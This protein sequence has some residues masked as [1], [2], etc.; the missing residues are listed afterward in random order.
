M[1]P[2]EKLPDLVNANAALVRR[3]RHFSAD[4][5]IEVGET[6]YLV[7]IAQGRIADVTP[8]R[9]NLQSW[10]FAIRAA[11][12]VWARFWQPVPAPGY[13]D[14]IALLRYGRLRFEGNLQPLMA[15]LIYLKLVLET[16]RALEAGR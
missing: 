10:T 8:I 2:I 14:L 6:Q 7:R 16:P 15:N 4:I 13:H 11:A 5:M 12:D 3:G 9:L 1:T